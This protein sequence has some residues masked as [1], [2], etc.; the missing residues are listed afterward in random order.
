[1]YVAILFAMYKSS[2]EHNR[3]WLQVRE[4]YRSIGKLDCI[5]ELNEGKEEQ[6]IMNDALEAITKLENE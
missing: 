3:N 2:K 5:M 1:M 6:Q 4:M